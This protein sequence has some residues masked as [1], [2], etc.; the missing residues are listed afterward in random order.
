MKILLKGQL[1][2]TA[3]TD[4]VEV[5]ILESQT[6][7]DVI[8][9]AAQNLPDAARNLILNDDGSVRAS[10]F[11]AADGEHTRDLAQPATATELTLMP[12]MAGG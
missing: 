10:L 12:P 11:I 4:C 2:T 3:E 8:Q 5:D 9:A 1:Q 6:L 7:T